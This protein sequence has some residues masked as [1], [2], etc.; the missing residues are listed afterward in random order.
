MINNLYVFAGVL[1][2][3]IYPA[4]AQLKPMFGEAH[5]IQQNRSVFDHFKI[6]VSA[7]G[8]VTSV[9]GELLFKPRY[10]EERY[11]YEVWN[12]QFLVITELVEGSEIF[13]MVYQMPKYELVIIDLFNSFKRYRVTL[14]GCFVANIDLDQLKITCLEEGKETTFEIEVF[15]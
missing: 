2:G 5:E 4:K 8:C 11:I 1:L 6:V 7:D 13:P 3:M 10:Q 12:N 9:Q 14:P 15:N